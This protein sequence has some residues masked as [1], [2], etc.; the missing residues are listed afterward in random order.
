MSSDTIKRIIQSAKSQ[1]QSGGYNAFSFCEIAKEIGIKSASIHYHSPTKADL[2]AELVQRYTDNFNQH[3]QVISESNGS[4]EQQLSD[5]AALLYHALKIDQ[6]MCL[7]RMFTA[8][9]DVLPD[10][11][12]TATRQFFEAQ[13]QC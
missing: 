9:I 8:E 12:K 3:L 6:K 11:V 1:A 4:T 5:Y 2:A 10:G 7:G 13:I